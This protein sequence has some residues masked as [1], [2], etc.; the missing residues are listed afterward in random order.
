MSVNTHPF[1]QRQDV[2]VKQQS[3]VER[4]EIVTEDLN[5]QRLQTL[6]RVSALVTFLFS[7]L[8]GLIGL[9][10][11]LKLMEANPRNAFASSIYNFTNLFLAPFSGLTIN[12][13]AGGIVL[14]ITSI[15]AMIVYALLAWAIIRLVWLVFYQPSNRTVTTYERERSPLDDSRKATEK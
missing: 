11:L 14:E 1:D 7:L 2:R 3:G 13:N 5:A 4:R 10:V 6:E 12:P 15:V 8:E 9:R